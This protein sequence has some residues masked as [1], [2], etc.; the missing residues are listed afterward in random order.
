MFSPPAVAAKGPSPDGVE[1]LNEG[2]D[3]RGVVGED[4]VLEVALPFRLCAHARASKIGA[5]E[6]RLDAIHDDALEMDARTEHPFHRRPKRRIAVE[7]I[8]PIRSW[9]FRMN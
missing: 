3:E 5:A 4:T 1:L 7:V 6:I 2:T 8:S 9:V